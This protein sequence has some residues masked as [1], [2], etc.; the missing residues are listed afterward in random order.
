MCRRQRREVS[1]GG[2]VRAEHGEQE[3]T[4]RTDGRVI[5]V[6]NRG[7]KSKQGCLAVRR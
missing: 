1:G 5:E 2:S 3:R 7:K 6:V 4:G